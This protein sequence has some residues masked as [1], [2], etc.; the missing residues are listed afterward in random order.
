VTLIEVGVRLTVE[1][2]V[3]VKVRVWTPPTGMT[4]ATLENTKVPA[5]AL[6]KVTVVVPLSCVPASHVT[7]TY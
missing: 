4:I 5:L 1:S 7:L 3:G 6:V 2:V